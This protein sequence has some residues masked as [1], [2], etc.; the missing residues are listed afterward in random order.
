MAD[1]RPLTRSR[2]NTRGRLL[3]AALEVFAEVGLDGASV[4]KVCERAGFTRGA[5]YS[6]F[7]SKGEL[8]LALIA[9]VAEAKI[10]EAETRV[11]GLDADS[12]S[13][14]PA[15][16]LRRLV[17]LSVGP[18]IDPA[19]SSEIR[20]QALRDPQMAKAYLAWQD[21]MIARISQIVSRLVDAYGFRLRL[22][23][24]EVARLFVQVADDTSVRAALQGLSEERAGELLNARA[25]RLAAA[26]VDP[27]VS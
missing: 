10:E 2:E 26:L 1:P 9:R 14:D 11:R 6:N 4:E 7:A 15:D 25:E 21:G 20:A 22:P 12:V 18:G 17:G 27:P 16:L 24:D 13:T 23:A 3:D 19:F 8:F 5:F